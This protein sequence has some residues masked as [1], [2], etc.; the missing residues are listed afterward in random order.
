MCS[1]GR[2]TFLAQ[3]GLTC[4][5][6]LYVIGDII[7]LLK[8]FKLSPAMIQAAVN[9]MCLICAAHT[10]KDNYQVHTSMYTY[11]CVLLSSSM[12]THHTYP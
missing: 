7:S 10:S 8:E 12:Y 6:L 2:V 11:T 9:A 4:A 1:S 3:I 5:P